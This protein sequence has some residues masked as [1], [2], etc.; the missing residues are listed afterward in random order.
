MT[1]S[2]SQTTSENL[3]KPATDATSEP[4]LRLGRVLGIVLPVGAVLAGGF[5]F[6][7]YYDGATKIQEWLQPAK[8]V[9]TGQVFLSDEPLSGGQVNTQPTAPGL[10]GGVG[11]TDSEGKFTFKMD[12]K[13]DF[14]DGI[15]VGEH[16]VTVRK[17]DPTSIGGAAAP[18]LLTPTQFADFDSTP[19]TIQVVA[20]GGKNHF[21]LRLPKGADGAKGG[22]EGRPPQGSGGGGPPAPPTAEE[23][24]KALIEKQDKDGDGQLNK[25][26]LKGVTGNIGAGLQSAD[27]NDDGMIDLAEITKTFHDLER[28][29]SL[30]RA[31]G[32]PSAPATPPK[33]E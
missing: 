29:N 6:W 25:E 15:F 19:L 33:S 13:G 8:V 31:K 17:Q 12:V 20:E 10:K 14:K 11:Y 16:K 1:D 21:E 4:K 28:S 5:W 24:A 32:L 27:A 9:A 23:S 7:G 26:E 30:F 3:A 22:G 2:S 18:A